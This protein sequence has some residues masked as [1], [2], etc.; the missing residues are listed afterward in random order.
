MRSNPD[1]PTLETLLAHSEFVR[2][3]ARTLVSDP[4][5][6]DDAVQQAWLVACAP[7]GPGDR[8]RP[9]PRANCDP[10]PGRW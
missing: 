9:G 6:A 8:L 3:L 2:G 10:G 1:R 5:T 4:A 7:A